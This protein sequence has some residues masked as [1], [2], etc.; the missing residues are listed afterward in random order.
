M[1]DTID[2]A[3]VWPPV[4][5]P[6]GLVSLLKRAEAAL[7]RRELIWLRDYDG[8]VTL[9]VARKGKM[10]E[11]NNPTTHAARYWPNFRKVNLLEDGTVEKN[12]QTDYCVHWIPYPETRKLF[13]YVKN[14][15][16]YSQLPTD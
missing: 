15:E 8:R 2:P 10:D 7:F 3:T 5:K 4:K 11:D 6:F 1:T 14:S 9:S 13:M 16:E 12:E